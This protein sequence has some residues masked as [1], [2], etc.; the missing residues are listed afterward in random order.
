MEP[1]SVVQLR[2]PFAAPRYTRSTA[3]QIN[4]HTTALM[5]H[6]PTTAAHEVCNMLSGDA[7]DAVA[8]NAV[9]HFQQLD[10]L[11]V[12]DCYQLNTILG[13]QAYLAGKVSAPAP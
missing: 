1:V 6:S 12:L 5:W 11:I 13:H 7:S 2:R 4:M 8:G 10:K 9:V 3:A